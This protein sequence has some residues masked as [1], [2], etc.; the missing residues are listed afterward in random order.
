MDDLRAYKILHEFIKATKRRKGQ[1]EK[2][3]EGGGERGTTDPCTKPQNYQL[4][5]EQDIAEVTATI[6]LGKK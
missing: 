3:G 4:F 6:H 1:G 2:R 5:L